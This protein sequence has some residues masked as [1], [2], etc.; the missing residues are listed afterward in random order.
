MLFIFMPTLIFE[1]AFAMDVHIFK[2]V[3]NQIILLA[4]PG[5][6]IGAA[7]TAFQ[8]RMMFDYEWSWCGP[9]APIPCTESS[10]DYFAFA[11]AF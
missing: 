1:S 10:T 2:K 9:S 7:L 8:V 3:F 4:G 6:L 11:F 5:M